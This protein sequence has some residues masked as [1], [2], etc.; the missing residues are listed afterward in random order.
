MEENKKE[1][2]K[3]IEMEKKEE[4]KEREKLKSC[5]TERKK[6]GYGKKFF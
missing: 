6:T 5:R 1:K 4:R 3:H 2:F